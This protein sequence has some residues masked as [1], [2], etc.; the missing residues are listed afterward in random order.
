[1]SAIRLTNTDRVLWPRAGFTKGEMIDYYGAVAG[2]L[3][4]HLQRRPLTLWRFPTGVEGPSWWQNEC[5]GAPEWLATY[6]WRGQRFCVV[7]DVDSLL[8]VANLG[9]IELHPFLHR[10]DLEAPD[11]VVFDLDPGPPAGVPECCD[12]ALRI[13]DRLGGVAKT[14]GVAGLHVYVRAGGR[15]YHE[16]KTL[17]RAVADEL[18]ASGAPVTASQSRRER[19]GRVLVDWLQNDPSRSTVAP[20]SLRGAPWPTVSTPVTWDEVER[21]ARARRPEELTFLARDVVARLERH[22]D[23]FS[24]LLRDS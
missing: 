14:S 21:C 12:V 8:W 5:R 2:A 24:P 7:D 3:V 1:M 23:L 4:P 22:G 6:E 10:V 17:A 19:A 11:V 18:A 16:T 13:R 20:Y 15:T 9:T